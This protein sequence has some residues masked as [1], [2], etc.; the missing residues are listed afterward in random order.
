M[1][2][3][4]HE[5]FSFLE[6]NDGMGHKASMAGTCASSDAGRFQLVSICTGLIDGPMVVTF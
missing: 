1:R 5:L 4:K 3:K 2:A 6:V